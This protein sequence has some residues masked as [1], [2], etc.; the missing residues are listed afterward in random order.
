MSVVILFIAGIWLLK[1]IWDH[2]KGNEVLSNFVDKYL[3]DKKVL[4]YELGNRG[5]RMQEVD[6]KRFFVFANAS[7]KRGKISNRLDQ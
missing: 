7:G 5:T 2:L 3:C 1:K 4:G 6:R